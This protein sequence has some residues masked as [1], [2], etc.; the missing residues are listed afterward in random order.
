MNKKISKILQNVD[1]YPFTFSLF[2]VLFLYSYNFGKTN[3]L[4]TLLS[5]DI[6]LLFSGILCL[7]FRFIFWNSEKASITT[8]VWVILVNSFGNFLYLF[9][10]PEIIDIRSYTY[11]FSGWL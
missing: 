6:T 11:V 3:F 1:F 8:T 9:F 7:F 5:F 2:P 4:E 10:P